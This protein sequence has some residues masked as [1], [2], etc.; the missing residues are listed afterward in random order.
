MEELKTFRVTYCRYRNGMDTDMEVTYR[1]TDFVI[2]EMKEYVCVRILNHI[3]TVAYVRNFDT[4]EDL[5][6]VTEE[7]I[8]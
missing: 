4:V 1:G 2:E 7:R 5:T 6:A 3:K 8:L